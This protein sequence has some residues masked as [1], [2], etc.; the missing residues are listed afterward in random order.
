MMLTYNKLENNDIYIYIYILV[1]CSCCFVF[2]CLFVGFV[3]G[4]RV[5]LRSLGCPGT[6]LLCRTRLASNSEICLPV[7]PKC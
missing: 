6:N 7:T 5:S 1:F 4:D 3:F 2:V